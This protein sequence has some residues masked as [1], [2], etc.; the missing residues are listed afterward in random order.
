M[1]V[2]GGAE[3]GESSGVLFLLELL[4]GLLAEVQTTTH[5]KLSGSRLGT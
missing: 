4:A 1:L 3:M 5:W 2:L